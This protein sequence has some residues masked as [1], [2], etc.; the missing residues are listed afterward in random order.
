MNASLPL[1]FAINFTPPTHEIK[2]HLPYLTDVQEKLSNFS[3]VSVCYVRR[4]YSFRVVLQGIKVIFDT[5][6]SRGHVSR[7]PSPLTLTVIFH[8]PA[9]CTT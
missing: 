9:R 6:H 1:Y 3:S 7:C 4:V 5:M 8:H 2:V